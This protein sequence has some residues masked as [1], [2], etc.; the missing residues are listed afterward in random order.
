MEWLW[1][2]LLAIIMTFGLIG[3]GIMICSFITITQ[4]D[5]EEGE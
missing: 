4:E 2:T 1:L 5:E 3:L